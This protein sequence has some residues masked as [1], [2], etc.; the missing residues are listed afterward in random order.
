MRIRSM[1]FKQPVPN[2]KIDG[3]NFEPRMDPDLLD[4]IRAFHNA[5]SV[6]YL[7]PTEHLK[8]NFSYNG[9]TQ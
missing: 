1:T 6:V 9:E 2:V 7:A 3:F 8:L 5:D 4:G